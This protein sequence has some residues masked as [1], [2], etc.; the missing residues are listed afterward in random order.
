[1]WAIWVLQTVSLC[2]VPQAEAARRGM[3]SRLLRQQLLYR[4]CATKIQSMWRG[5]FE[6]RTVRGCTSSRV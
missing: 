2:A 4:N 5:S 1:M 6:R 3:K